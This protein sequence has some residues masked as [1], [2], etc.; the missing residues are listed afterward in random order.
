VFDKP[1]TLN[2]LRAFLQYSARKKRSLND[3]TTRRIVVRTLEKYWREL[4]LQIRRK[5]GHS[6][7]HREKADMDRVRKQL[8]AVIIVTRVDHNI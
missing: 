1:L 7:S 4:Q 5:T 3:Y 2:S 8:L 6:Y